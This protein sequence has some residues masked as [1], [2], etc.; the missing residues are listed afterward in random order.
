M[1]GITWLVW[2]ASCLAVAAVCL[3]V[4]ARRRPPGGPARGP[5][6]RE[7]VRRWGHGA[8]WLLLAVSFG[9]RWLGASTGELAA[10]PLALAA[11]VMYGTFLASL[12]RR[13][14]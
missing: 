8:V 12:L 4:A 1:L 9:L 3:A 11:L 14:R 5:P 6:A 10:D 13:C 2:G 7:L